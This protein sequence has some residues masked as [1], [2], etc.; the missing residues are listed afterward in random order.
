VLVTQA[1]VRDCGAELAAE[2]LRE[3]T[4]KDERRHWQQIERLER[5]TE[6]DPLPAPDSA[7]CARPR[8]S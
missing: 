2:L 3:P 1:I 5:S 4:V 8:R 7:L 6:A